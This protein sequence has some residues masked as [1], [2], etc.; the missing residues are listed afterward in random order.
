MTAASS[1]QSIAVD[2]S[3]RGEFVRNT[4]ERSGTGRGSISLTEAPLET[5]AGRRSS[6]SSRCLDAERGPRS[7]LGLGLG[8][9]LGRIMGRPSGPSRSGTATS[10][11]ASSPARPSGTRPAAARSGSGSRRTQASTGGWQ[12]SSAT[13][14]PV[15]L[16]PPD[17]PKARERLPPGLRIDQTDRFRSGGCSRPAGHGR[18]GRP[19]TQPA[20]S[21]RASGSRSRRWRSSGRRGLHPGRRGR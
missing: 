6:S 19:R 13:D 11:P 7:P 16:T 20:G 2:A 12:S 5:I 10:R 14:L 3:T 1:P 4:I 8:F 17:M 18:H 15:P 21:P 9:G